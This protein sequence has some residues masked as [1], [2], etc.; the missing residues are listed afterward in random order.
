MSELKELHLYD[1]EKQQSYPFHVTQEE[2]LR[3]YAEPGYGSQL[4]HQYMKKGYEI[5]DVNVQER[6]IDAS[7]A[8]VEES[9]SQENIAPNSMNCYEIADVNVQEWPIDASCA[10]VEESIS[11]ENIAPN[12]MNSTPHNWTD[13]G[14]FL[15]IDCF[16]KEGVHLLSQKKDKS[17]ALKRATTKFNT[18][19]LEKKGKQIPHQKCVS[20]MDLLKR[21]YKEKLDLKN[22]SRGAADKWIFF[23]VMH[24]LF[25]KER[26]VKPLSVAGNGIPDN[27]IEVANP[28]PRR[29]KP[30]DHFLE[31]MM[32]ERRLKKETDLLYRR[33]K[34]SRLDRL[35][36]SIESMAGSIAV[37]AAAKKAKI[38]INNSA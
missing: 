35:N 11:Q 20:K 15:W 38:D 31:E 10:P 26:W 28:R 3:A 7:C 34:M 5:A 14:T 1:E 12:S 27:M 29:E 33:E 8:S 16:A 30:L 23:D 24:E 9:I 4:L 18:I 13:D 36:D 6:P 17:D 2:Y 32:V 22:K 21:L 19:L 37:I 25:H